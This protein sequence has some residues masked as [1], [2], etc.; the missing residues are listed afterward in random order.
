MTK[1][2]GIKNDANFNRYLWNDQMEQVYKMSITDI[3]F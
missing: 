3:P 1:R 2:S